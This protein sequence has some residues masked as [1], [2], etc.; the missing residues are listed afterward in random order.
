MYRI[1]TGKIIRIIT[2]SVA[3]DLSGNETFNSVPYLD[4]LI[5]E[6]FESFSNIS[7]RLCVYTK[8]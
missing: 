6:D 4:G 3:S 7:S 5:A 2:E 1:F 8:I